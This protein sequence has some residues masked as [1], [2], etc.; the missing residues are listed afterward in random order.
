MQ[1]SILYIQ[2]Y[3]GLI[4]I[5]NHNDGLI[6]YATIIVNCLLRH[7]HP[8]SFNSSVV[9]RQRIASVLLIFEAIR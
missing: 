7:L 4:H 2:Y 8:L 6:L 5:F 9:F 1:Q 3:I